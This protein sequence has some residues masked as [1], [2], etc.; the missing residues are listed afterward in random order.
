MA[1]RAYNLA[2]GCSGIIA[3]V[4]G[5]SL[6]YR[7]I[8]NSTWK[9]QS[10]VDDGWEQPGYD[11]SD[12]PVAHEVGQN[13]VVAG[14]SWIPLPSLPADAFWIWSQGF[15]DY[16]IIMNCRTTLPV[17]Q[18]NVCENGGTC[19]LNQPTLCRCPVHYG[20]RFCELE[21]DECDAQPC[22]NG[23]LCDLIDDGLGYICSCG[24]GYTGINCETDTTPCASSP[25]ENEGTCIYDIVDDSYYC[26]CVNGFTGFNCE[27]DIDEC[28][29]TPC[30]NGATCID[31][32]DAVTCV[33]VPG[34]TGNLCQIQ[35]NFCAS[36]PC[37][38]GATCNQGINSYTCSCHP[39]TTGNHCEIGVGNCAVNPCLNGGTCTLDGQGEV[40]CLCTEGWYG[41]RCEFNVD[42]CQSN[43]CLH[44]GTCITGDNRYDC[45]CNPAYT[46][47]R[48][49]FVVPHCGS[50]MAQSVYSPV[51]NFW[52]LCEINIIDHFQDVNTPCR[53]LI[54]DINHYGD[55]ENILA[56]G[57]SFGCFVTR[58]PEEM[59][60]G[61][62]VPHYNND[63]R[64]ANCL[65]C[66]HMGVGI[67][68]L[69]PTT[70]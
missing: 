54:A 26:S 27:T 35:I 67:Y 9:C 14:C 20:G 43:P 33:C 48:C 19:L 55:S 21:I 8:T 24:V 29:S 68:V 10:L 15:I 25:C 34:F 52:V 37:Q 56:N 66:T 7:I 39:G 3:T 51:R 23:G 6:G 58:Y 13:G 50:R 36:N 11:D 45:N 1:I 30:A 28:E 42:F 31:G 32:I 59:A 17:C 47:D 22:Q 16:D 53:E 57:G 62:C 41:Q 40:D 18:Y 70:P 46:G 65:S 4:Q 49:E 64:L 61:A 2:E 44:N 12:W 63:Q 60:E 38:N 69:P 5:G